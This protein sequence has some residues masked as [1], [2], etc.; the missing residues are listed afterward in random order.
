MLCGPLVISLLALFPHCNC[1]FLEMYVSVINNQRV[2]VQS[3]A[4]CSHVWVPQRKRLNVVAEDT[5][6]E[7]VWFIF[8]I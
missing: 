1:C 7:G 5:L 6:L 8:T 2:P 4:K 3:K